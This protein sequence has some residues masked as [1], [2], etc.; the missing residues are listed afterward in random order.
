M[1]NETPKSASP[2]GELPKPATI[3]VIV[4]VAVLVIA[5]AVAVVA[6]ARATY[7]SGYPGLKRNYDA[8]QTSVHQGMSCTQCHSDDRGV[9]V[10]Q[11]ALVGEF[12]YRLVKKPRD[13]RFIKIGPPKNDACLE[14]HLEDWSDDAKKTT[15][16]PHP[17]HL[18]VSEETREC[19]KCHKWTAHEEAYM[20]KHTSMPFSTVCAS[21][22]CHVGFKQADD[23]KNCHH[24]LQEAKGS[25][26]EIHPET[27][28]EAGP[29]GC[30]ES[31]HTSD[32]CRMCHTTG[33]RPEFANM[34]IQSGLK[35]IEQAHVKADWLSQHGTMALQDQS[36][37]LLCHVSEG[38]CQDCHSKRPAFHGPEESWLGKHKDLA[39]DKRRCLT[40][41]KEPWCNECHDQFKEMR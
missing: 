11:I 36:K 13:P 38:E 18:R 28:R 32:Q 5:I 15:K 19:V 39:K 7:F 34:S 26:K 23:C 16:V 20:E 25:W 27:V 1:S 35:A 22:E 12:Y 10:H 14:C 33:K 2:L 3:A 6:T 17:A 41:H 37:C 40:C 8:L 30:L 21:F 4:V 31:C 29:N 24:I 9:V